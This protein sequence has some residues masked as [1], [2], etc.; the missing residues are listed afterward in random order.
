MR[1][2]CPIDERGSPAWSSPG[3]GKLGSFRF[4]LMATFDR[5]RS[6]LATCGEPRR[7]ELVDE[8]LES[9]CWMPALMVAAAARETE[10]VRCSGDGVWRLRDS[11]LLP[12]TRDWNGEA[13]GD[14]EGGRE[15][16]S[17]AMA[18]DGNLVA[19][20]KTCVDIL[21]CMCRSGDTKLVMRFVREICLNI[22]VLSSLLRSSLRIV[23]ACTALRSGMFRRFMSPIRLT[24]VRAV[25]LLQ[26][27]TSAD[28]GALA[29]THIVVAAEQSVAGALLRSSSVTGW[30]SFSR[31]SQNN[32]S[33]GDG[34]RAAEHLTGLMI[35]IYMP[36]ERA[37]YR[38]TALAA[39]ESSSPK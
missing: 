23:N 10:E 26:G 13:S 9:W 7:L 4:R 34:A 24:L 11:A 27:F 17:G 31:C 32:V 20:A 19:Y 22:T 5:R 1:K 18:E 38:D 14:L 29:A 30:T 15:L 6:A 37:T 3:P 12:N 39:Y 33:T 8:R 2:A 21:N 35:F 25:E 28:S 16:R 36:K